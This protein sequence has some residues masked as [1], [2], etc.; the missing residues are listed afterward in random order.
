M[1]WPDRRLHARCITSRDAQTVVLAGCMGSSMFV[2]W[3][4]CMSWLEQAMYAGLCHRHACERYACSRLSL[5]SMS[6][7]LALGLCQRQHPANVGLRLSTVLMSTS[8]YVHRQKQSLGSALC[9]VMQSGFPSNGRH[10]DMHTCYDTGYTHT[11]H[12]LPA[13]LEACTKPD[14]AAPTACTGSAHASAQQC[15]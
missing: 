14:A 4:S 1:A 7:W 8:I 9:S 13:R 10:H 3:Q 2:S 15:S 5:Q 6:A 11:G 12:R